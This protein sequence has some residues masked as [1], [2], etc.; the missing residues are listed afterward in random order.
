MKTFAIR[1]FA[2]LLMG[3]SA[4]TV[5]G[6]T[7]LIPYVIEFAGGPFV[8][9][10]EGVEAVGS[11]TLLLRCTPP[12]TFPGTN[13]VR[14]RL[15]SRDITAQR[16]SDYQFPAEGRMLTLGSG[17]LQ[18]AVSPDGQTQDWYVYIPLFDD[19]VHEPD[20]TFEVSL[21]EP[22]SNA[23]LGGRAKVIA[24]IHNSAPT[25]SV[26]LSPA[27]FPD[28]SYSLVS[29]DSGS[30]PLLEVIRRGDRELPV[31][32]D[33]TF[34]GIDESN[35]DGENLE[36]KGV[37]GVDFQAVNQRVD[38]ASGET[39]RSIVVPILDDAEVEQVGEMR[40]FGATLTNPSAGADIAAYGG[41]A[42]VGIVN[43]ELPATLD[44][45]RDRITGSPLV[46]FGF[47]YVQ[48]EDGRTN[49]QTGSVPADEVNFM[50]LPG[51]KTLAVG[52]FDLVNGVRRPG[53]ARLD[54]NDELDQG[55]RPPEGLIPWSDNGYLQIPR[56]LVLQSG[57]LLVPDSSRLFVR[58]KDD[59]SRDTSFST[60]LSHVAE[61]GDGSLWGVRSNEVVHLT[62]DG[63]VLS[64]RAIPARST[65]QTIFAIQADGR[66]LI[67][68]QAV[69]ANSGEELIGLFRWLPDGSI[70]PSFSAIQT[71][72]RFGETAVL[73]DGRLVTFGAPINGGP[74]TL[75]V[76]GTDGRIDP[77][78]PPVTA[79]QGGDGKYLYRWTLQGRRLGLYNPILET[80]NGIS[81]QPGAYEFVLTNASKT[82]VQLAARRSYDPKT[83]DLQAPYY[84]VEPNPGEN[85]AFNV[86]FRRLGRSAG[87]AY[88]NYT[89]RDCTAI[90]G[91]NYLAQSGSI[92]FAP[93]EV[94]KTLLIPILGDSGDQSGG[95]FEVVV[96]GAGGFE[97]LP[98]P[99]QFVILD[100]SG[101]RP[102]PRVQDV[103]RLRDGRV[104]IRTA[105]I[106]PWGDSNAVL[107]ASDNLQA[108]SMVGLE[109]GDSIDTRIG[110]DGD[111]KNHPTRFYRFRTVLP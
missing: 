60:G 6:Q 84:R 72:R 69:D 52:R 57:A 54:A 87:S 35:G 31:S 105:S 93:L 66:L 43:N 82:A 88:V 92:T 100:R 14:V 99:V 51:G 22:S 81:V 56:L 86:V 18:S 41:Y 5:L 28:G 107:E 1:I 78:F 12:I 108:W 16:G 76:F 79:E 26:R 89:T 63:S 29:E 47:E 109:L 38:F 53:V 17:G 15:A 37:P 13:E 94:E 80:I 102:P 4:T 50:P 65:N 83:G 42:G 49:I 36:L 44:V 95:I 59:G 39:I 104:L 97:A 40:F 67:H 45:T 106:Y 58:L 111:A 20:E 91:K 85:A 23:V 9:P 46:L 90:A 21:S 73:P 33:L 68:D 74:L 62:L 96:T 101:A 77:S 30:R 70:D 61:A 103:K 25:L 27:L 10:P 11:M 98:A 34:A 110:L 2:T 3:A 7:P 71:S 55:F 32:V 8:G 48:F 24:T 75:Q 64:S 19:G